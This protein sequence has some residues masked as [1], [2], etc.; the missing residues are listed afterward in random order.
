MY[1][2]FIRKLRTSSA[3]PAGT[4]N[5]P[6]CSF[7]HM[8]GQMIG[9]PPPSSLTY[10]S[11]GLK[12]K[13]SLG[14]IRY[15]LKLLYIER[16]TASSFS[17]FFFSITRQQLTAVHRVQVDSGQWTVDSGQWTVDSGQW[18]VTVYHVKAHCH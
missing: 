1:A 17:F 7:Y 18:T 15:H 16:L 12:A 13:G 11:N 5:T 8:P 2:A 4:Y 3:P 10:H 6:S 9:P 14:P